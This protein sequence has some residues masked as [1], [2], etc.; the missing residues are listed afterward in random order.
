VARHCIDVALVG[1]GGG[2]GG[3]GGAS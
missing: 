1:S 3:G 2:G